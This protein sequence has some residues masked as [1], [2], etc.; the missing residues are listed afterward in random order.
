MTDD[1]R[2]A[3]RVA[4]LEAEH[5]H[6][7]GKLDDMAAKVDELHSIMTEAK[8]V[9]RAMLFALPVA[10]GIVGAKF[11]AIASFFGFK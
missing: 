11:T 2:L 9:K 5:R 4:V 6:V 10:S 8:G 1:Q 3:E 7:I